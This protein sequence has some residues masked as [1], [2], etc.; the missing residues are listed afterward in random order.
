MKPHQGL[1][2]R[3]YALLWALLGAAAAPLLQAQGTAA[4]S[5]DAATLS[6]YDRNHNGVIDADEQ[7]AI[8]ADSRSAQANVTTTGD[9]VVSLS[10]FEV[11]ENNKG[12][13]ATNTMSGTRFNSKLEDLGASITVVTK[14][15][16]A[17]F[18]MLDI[19]DIFQYT[20]GTEGTGTYTDVQINRNGDVTDNV[21][22]SP[23]TAN[24]V[25]GLS[26][27]NISFNNF[28]MS[29]RMP[30]DPSITNGVEISRGP[31]ANVFGLG[32]PG[33]T[34]NQVAL[35]PNL[36]RDRSSTEFRVDSYGGY[37][38][39][40]D[41]NRVLVKGKLSIRGTGVFQHDAFIRKPAGVDTERYNL[42]LKFQPFKN[43][44]LTAGAFYYHQYGTRPNF[45]NPRDS[46]SYWKSQGSPT[47]DPVTETVHVNGKTLGPFSSDA[48]LALVTDALQRSFTGNG[49]S[50]LYIDRGGVG[51]FGAPTTFGLSAGQIN[52]TTTAQTVRLMASNSAAGANLGKI[53][54]QPLFTTTPSVSD[55]SLYDWTKIN[56]GA[57]NYDWDTDLVSTVQLDQI[58]LNTPMHM[59]AGQVAFLRED[60]ERYRRDHF[61]VANDNG[62]SGQLFVDVNER[63]LDGTPNPYFGRMYVGQDQPRTTYQPLKWDSYRAQLAYRLDL[64]HEKGLLK[65]LGMHQI[66]GYDEYKYRIQRRYSYREAI[67]DDHPWIPAGISRGNQGAISGG[68]SAALAITRS[69]LRYYVG[70]ANTGRVDYAPGEF[71]PGTYPF[72]WG[73]Y[74]L[75][76]GTSA[77][78]PVAGSG[79][80]KSEP[81]RVGLAAVTDST[82]GGSNV[83]TIMKTAGAVV[84]SH[85][86]DDRIVTTFGRREDKQYTKTGSI[87]QQLIYPQG[88]EFNMESINHWR[89]GDYSFNSGI[90]TQAGVVVRP[91]KDLPF[92]KS[93]NGAGDAGSFLGSL[94]NGLYVTYNK[95]NSFLPQD[96]KINL[97]FQELPN[98]TANGKDYG[99]G[100][101]LFDN[102]LAFRWNH[103][104][105]LVNNFR[106]GD[107]STIAQ[108]V[109]RIDIT[110]TARFLLINQMA[111]NSPTAI[112]PSGNGTQWGWIYEQL[113]HNAT[114][115][116]VQ[117][118]IT[119]Q[120]GLPYT[121]ILRLQQ[122][123]N[124]G[125][126]ASTQDQLA[127][128]DE[129]EIHFNPSRNLSMILNGS[130]Q[131]T[132]NTNISSELDQ[133][134]KER[135]A[136]WTTIRDPR[137]PGQPLW[138]TTSYGGNQT[139][140]QNFETF[141]RVPFSV[142][143][144]QEGKS[145]PQVR[146]YKANLIGNYSLAGIT[147]NKWLKNLSVG[148]A[149][150][151]EDKG[152]IGNYG[153]LG[154]D[155]VTYV[156][157]D[158]S[159]PIY[160]KARTYFDFISSY[161]MKL[162]HNRVSATF[163]FKIENIQES[164]RIQAVAAY[165]DGTANTYRI[166][167]PRR[168]ILSSTF[169]F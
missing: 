104:N 62:Q 117:A 44:T 163:R 107:A 56:L 99:L 22:N 39:G 127:K 120:M 64:T 147:E 35:V 45:V 89:A 73:T 160:D 61:G 83:K 80:F 108:R 156:D 158:P 10:P 46:V 26:N 49:H 33:G 18:A 161:R 122:E 81:S 42:T 125:T 4:G 90:T 51:Y 59:V 57:M 1:Q 157:L 110:S 103:Y 162:W 9:D 40:L 105:T 38:A 167:D 37:R 52:P 54:S 133:W 13:M 7:A 136:V 19:N 124:N 159:R 55:K 132:I 50:Y 12:Y 128:G 31:N 78:I 67:L 109:T 8:D 113:G 27:A 17:D 21:Q 139:A 41:L 82:G 6:R 20:A 76:T 48:N 138:W 151:W 3:S 58:F 92:I 71:Q 14:E 114:D 60:S 66:S 164:G 29:G 131:E 134:I 47:W 5:P 72:V 150:R 112:A 86:L 135:M 79:V 28:E 43:T 106:Q 168:F 32:Q 121:T 16:M 145:N 53:G 15:Q 169:D 100:F 166:V 143:K 153:V 2:V 68:P 152:A 144:A 93:M 87:P 102:K 126:I 75:G 91:F 23:T 85:F 115:A 69:Y 11:V 155:G 97:Y 130:K 74:T 36:T 98:T 77:G 119:K 34:V 146:K 154:S 25:R 96:P 101:S 94:L 141:V 116:Q 24:R 165:P 142:A 65:L 84:Q 123:F 88:I 118:E 30:I 95:S 140:A 63:N 70:D 149:I 137:L 129:L 111:Q 148:G